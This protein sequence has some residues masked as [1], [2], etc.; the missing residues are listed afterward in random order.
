MKKVKKTA[1][2]KAKIEVPDGLRQQF[3]DSNGATVELH[4]FLKEG[5]WW[6]KKSKTRR[7]VILTHDAVKKI[8]KR[9]GVFITSY[10]VLTQ[11]DCYN[12][13]QYTIQATVVDPSGVPHIE[14]GESNRNNLG[15]KGRNN[16]AN[17]A[18]KRAFD[19]AVLSAVG[20]VGVLSEDELAEE[21]E[22]HM[23]TLTH[24]EKKHIAPLINNILLAKNKKDLDAFNMSMRKVSINYNSQQLDYLRGLF[25]KRLA[26]FTKSF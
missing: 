9:A 17:M 22:E 1:I 3:I 20:L 10:T 19:R 11:P 5:D 24:E 21:D 15:G 8:S 12:N 18:Q 23:E 6:E 25:K 26:E 13:Y 2:N 7:V 4:T 14:I 16:P